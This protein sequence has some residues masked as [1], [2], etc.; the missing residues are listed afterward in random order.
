MFKK[1]NLDTR[2]ILACINHCDG[3]ESGNFKK[4]NKAAN[5][6]YDVV[7]ELNNQN[8]LQYLTQFLQHENDS[9]SL[10]SAAYL[11]NV[12]PEIALSA[13]ENLIGK[14]KSLVSFSAK[15]TLSE[16]Q[17]GTLKMYFKS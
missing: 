12:K 7:T 15:V 8:N 9:V 13:L 2:F 4:A 16:W 14:P 5:Q 11:L 3:T 17:K 10:W 6:I 1:T